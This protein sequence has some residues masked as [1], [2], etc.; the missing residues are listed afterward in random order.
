[1]SQLDTF[2]DP[3]WDLPTPEGVELVDLPAR[4]P[5][6]LEVPKPSIN[7]PTNS[8]ATA[9]EG[10]GVRI[11]RSMVKNADAWN[12]AGE[13]VYWTAVGAA[14]YIAVSSLWNY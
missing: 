14:A 10:M 4:E 2:N 8:V 6:T 11:L 5:E 1:M 12:D 9:Q 7:L 3:A 13:F